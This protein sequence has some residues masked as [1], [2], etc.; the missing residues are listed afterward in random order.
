[1]EGLVEAPTEAATGNA[2]VTLTFDAWK[3]GA[4][5]PAVVEVPVHSSDT[6]KK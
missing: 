6:A 5:K 3:P 2:Q 4:V 1:L